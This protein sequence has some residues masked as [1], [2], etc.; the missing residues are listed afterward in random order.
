LGKKEIP[1]AEVKEKLLKHFTELFEAEL[2]QK[3]EAI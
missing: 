2:K 3:S 1:I